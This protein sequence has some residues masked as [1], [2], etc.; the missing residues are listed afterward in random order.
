[1]LATPAVHLVRGHGRRAVKSLLLRSVAANVGGLLAIAA[2]Q[3]CGDGAPPPQ[4]ALFD[5][6]FLCELD[7]VGYGAMGG[8]VVASLIDAAFM[9]DEPGD[10]P[11]AAWTPRVT[12]TRDGVRAGVAFQW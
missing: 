6:D 9:T 1:M 10:T 11:D 8:L 7:Y 4:G 5:D 12:A 2:N 3:G